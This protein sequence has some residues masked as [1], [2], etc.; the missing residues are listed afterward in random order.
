LLPE[1][2]NEMEILAKL[3]RGIG[4]NYLVIK[5][6]SQHP[7]SVT[8]KYQNFS[9]QQDEMKNLEGDLSGITGNNFKVIFRSQTMERINTGKTYSKCHSTPFFWGYLSSMGDVYSC[10]VFLGD[11]RFLLGN[12][13]K[14]SFQ[15]IWEGDKRRKNWELMKNFDASNCRNGCRMDACNRYLDLLKNPQQHVNFI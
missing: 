9:Y 7:Q 10:S 3:A 2:K 11:E 15:E 14:Q 5:P 1:N 13:Y 4:C 12:I 6:Y 8:K